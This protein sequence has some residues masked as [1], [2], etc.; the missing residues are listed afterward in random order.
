[1]TLEPQVAT[2]AE[3]MFPLLND[4]AVFTYIDDAP[5][6]SVDALRDRFARLESRASA[7]GREQWL[8]W[9]IRLDGATV[10]GFVQ[11]TVYSNGSAWIAFVLGRAHWGRGHAW[12]ATRAMIDELGTRYGATRLLATADRENRRS[13][14]LLKRLG[15][16]LGG[17]DLRSTHDVAENDVLLVR[18]AGA[19]QGAGTIEPTV[20]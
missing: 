13:I 14:A 17:D 2:H 15:F 7:D 19:T 11:A 10:A 8:N 9:V 1:M 5:P 12:H 3:A 18:A 16:E 20:A 6:V 4:T